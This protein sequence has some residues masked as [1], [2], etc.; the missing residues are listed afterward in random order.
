[1]MMRERGDTPWR[2]TFIYVFVVIVIVIVSDCF[3]RLYVSGYCLFDKL[4][5]LV[6]LHG[7]TS[8]EAQKE[9]TSNR[10]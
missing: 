4:V 6:K 2:P 3:H 5:H 9:S 1:M 7:T 10:S 8:I